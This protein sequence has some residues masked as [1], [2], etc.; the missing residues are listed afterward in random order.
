MPDL[1]TNVTRRAYHG[2]DRLDFTRFDMTHV[3]PFN[4]GLHFGTRAAVRDTHS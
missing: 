3:N 4:I 1:S 2:T